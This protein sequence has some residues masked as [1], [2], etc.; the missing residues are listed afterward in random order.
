MR[1]TGIFAERET[2][3]LE[4]ISLSLFQSFAMK[5]KGPFFNCSSP[6]TLYKRYNLKEWTLRSTKYKTK[7]LGADVLIVQ[8]E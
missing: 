8:K 4:Y 1:E 2:R 3:L 6:Y 7:E 5:S